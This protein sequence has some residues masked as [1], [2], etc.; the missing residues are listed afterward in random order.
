MHQHLKD[1]IYRGAS[2]A[3]AKKA[4]I[5]IHGRGATPESI[6]GLSSYLDLGDFALLAPRAAQHS[7]YPY[8]FMAPEQQNEPGLSTALTVLEE[9]V[10]ELRTANFAYEDIYFLGFSQGAC[11]ASEY[12]ARHGR[13]YGGLFAYSG[14]LIGAD[15]DLSKYT[16]TFDGMP[17]LLGCS[18]TDA[19]IPLARVK[20]TTAY[21]QEA[22]ATV[23]E[24]IYPN[25]AH[26][27]FE[28]EIKHTNAIL[29]K[30]AT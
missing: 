17:V 27:V 6:L 4:I 3:V 15:L 16:G 8:S 21:F 14:G 22:G 29:A 19:H 28:D 7:W 24:R 11:L 26:T 1:I 23:T 9:V 2:L 13:K 25:G 18:D 5:M 12:V 10:T 30:A 20:E